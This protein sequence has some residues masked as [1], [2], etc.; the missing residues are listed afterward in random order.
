M[1]V[2]AR[3]L[4][5]LALALAALAGPAGAAPSRPSPP[6][7]AA[8]APRP[9]PPPTLAPAPAPDPF[10][11][12]RPAAKRL[13]RDGL[14]PELAAAD[15]SRDA[16]R[17]DLDRAL[18]LLTGAAG[19]SPRPEAPA[20]AWTANLLFV[21]ALGLEAERR[22]LN[23]LATEDG[24]PL[25][26][27]RNFG[28]E[29]LARELGLVHNY[30]TPDEG[31]ERGRRETIRLADLAAKLDRALA[32]SD[33]ERARLARYRDV[34][35]PAM[36]PQRLAVVQA[37]LW[38]VGQP[39]VWAGDWPGPRSPWGAQARGGFD[40][41][42][43]VWWAF[44]GSGVPRSLDLGSGLLGRTADDMAFERRAERAPVAELAPGDLVFFG[45][46]GPTSRRGTISHT[47]IALG[48][49]WMVHSSGSRGG[50]SVSHLDDYWPSATAWGRRVAA[51]GA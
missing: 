40:C 45:P 17:A 4:L 49:G 9:A 37:A 38:Q 25:R 11:W 46:R 35:L 7:P 18:A 12:A 28:S 20:S 2:T 22:G 27:P 42:G 1:E 51:L 13:V 44:K 19:V 15:L 31:L 3:M 50:V 30:L 48:G 8:V 47:G 33:W 6:P 21:R 10:A 36:S 5:P 41:S 32:V 29:V 43:L 26:L 23:R 14:W 16:T 34:Q 39:Y 24:Q